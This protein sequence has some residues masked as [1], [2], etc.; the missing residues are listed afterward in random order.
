MKWMTFTLAMWVWCAAGCAWLRPPKDGAARGT[1][2]QAPPPT[3]MGTGSEPGSR[4]G[5]APKV[6]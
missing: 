6:R 2:G 5:D 4:P 1:Q 3:M